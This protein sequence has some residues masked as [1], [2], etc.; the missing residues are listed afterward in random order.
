M[1][2]KGVVEKAHGKVF[3]SRLFTVPKKNSDKTRLVMDLSALNKFLKP[4]HFKMVTVAQVRA[5]LSKEDWLASLD[6]QDAYWHVPIHTRFRRFLAFQVGTET[7]Q[8]TRLPFGLSLAPRI[9]TKLS[10]IVTSVLA[11]Q[12]V[13]TLVYLDDWL[14]YSP[15]R[16][17]TLTSVLVAVRVLGEMGFL[18]NLPKSSLVPSVSNGIRLQRRC[19]CRNTTSGRLSK[20]FAEP[21]SPTLQTAVGDAARDSQLRRSHVPPGSPHAPPPHAGSQRGH[22]HHAQ[23]QTEACPSRPAHATAWLVKPRL[24]AFRRTLANTSLLPHHHLGRIRRGLGVPVRSRPPELRPLASRTERGTHKR[25]GTLGGPP[26]PSGRTQPTRQSSQTVPRQLPGSA[27]YQQAGVIEVTPTPR[28]SGENSH[29]S[30]P[31]EHPPIRSARKGSGQRLGRRTV[32]FQDDISRMVAQ[33]DSVPLPGLQVRNPRGRPLRVT[34]QH[35]ATTVPIT[36]GTDPGR[37][38]RRADSGLEQ[39]GLH[40]P[41]PSPGDEDAG[42]HHQ[43]AQ[44]LPRQGAAGGSTVEGS[45]VVRNSPQLVPQSAPTRLNVPRA[46]RSGSTALILKSSR[47]V[48]LKAGLSSL[49]PPSVVDTMIAAHRPSSIN[50]YESCWRRFQSFLTREKVKLVSQATVLAFLAWLGN[51]T[52]RVPSTVASHHSALADPLKFSLGIRVHT[53]ALKLLLRGLRVKRPPSRRVTP[54]WSLHK[55]LQFLE[56]RL[57]PLNSAGYLMRALFLIA[58]ATGFRSSQLAA[59]TRHPQFSQLAQDG[60][61]LTLSPSPAFLAKNETSESLIAPITIPALLRV[62]DLTLCAPWQPTETT[63]VTHHGLA[64]STFSTIPRR[65]NHSRLER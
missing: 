49:F 65:S 35:S 59:L 7:Y 55:V 14:V 16:E 22:T 50:Q 28:T 31:Q 4:Q 32:T 5:T 24:M 17:K 60:S 42:T 34:H 56:T 33:D 36:S 6:L 43:Q 41:L 10:K 12:G 46:A 53:R 57:V 40:I 8:F 18:L 37:R 3:L 51:N 64:R 19:R 20:A 26:F 58:L 48:F 21:P 25:Q 30:S 47:L 39:V 62:A 2:E 44:G 13:A 11:D 15:S 38:P 54:K 9:F 29:T 1:V 27:Q 63:Y 52:N 23:G 45:A 61:S